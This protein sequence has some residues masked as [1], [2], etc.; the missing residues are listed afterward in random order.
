MSLPASSVYVLVK[1]AVCAS[2]SLLSFSPCS[3]GQIF[4]AF[5][6]VLSGCCWCAPDP[7]HDASNPCCCCGA[8]P[9]TFRRSPRIRL[10]SSRPHPTRTQSLKHQLSQAAKSYAQA[11]VA[12]NG[13]RGH[14]A[15]TGFSC[16]CPFNRRAAPPF[17]IR[18]P[19]MR[20]TLPA[21]RRRVVSMQVE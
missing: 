11:P 18:R 9:W 16:S 12:R 20:Q 14:G 7:L 19:A 4:L 6:L 21:C 13:P 5:F 17:S 15:S 2:C 10:D 3:S 1:K 8:G